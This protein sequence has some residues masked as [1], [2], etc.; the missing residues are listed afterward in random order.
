M[1]AG[2][3]MNPGGGT[4]CAQYGQQCTDSAQC[5]NGVPCTN[6]FCVTLVR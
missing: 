1:D 5:C 4:N 3:V 2:V 6:G